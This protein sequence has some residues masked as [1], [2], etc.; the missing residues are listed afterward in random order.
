MTNKH[1]NALAAIFK[2][3]SHKLMSSRPENETAG[4]KHE[5]R[6]GEGIISSESKNW[7]RMGED[8]FF[9]VIVKMRRELWQVTGAS[10]L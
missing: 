6:D 2:L 10:S 3:K 4:Q 5:N 9:Y 8:F 1:I 7:K